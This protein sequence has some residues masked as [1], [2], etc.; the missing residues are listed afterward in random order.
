MADRYG[1]V[2]ANYD[3]YINIVLLCKY[4]KKALS[5]DMAKLAIEKLLKASEL[6]HGQAMDKV[7]DYKINKNS[8]VLKVFKELLEN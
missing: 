4:N 2:Q 6:C 7:N 8:N 3:I 5:E 1:Y